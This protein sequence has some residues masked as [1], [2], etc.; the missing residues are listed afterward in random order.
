VDGRSLP[1]LWRR[2]A[3][4]RAGVASGLVLAGLPARACEFFSSTLRVT[5]PWTR[6]TPDGVDSCLVCMVFDEVREDERLIGIRTDIAAGAE[7]AG[8]DARPGV[9]FAIPKG[10]VSALSESGTCIRLLGLNM[11]ME[12]AR[13]YPIDLIFERG[14]VLRADLSVDYARFR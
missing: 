2:R 9:H 7:M 1:A 13:V 14:G 5:H 6:A 4:L 12:V 10:R 8:A 3:W 11:P